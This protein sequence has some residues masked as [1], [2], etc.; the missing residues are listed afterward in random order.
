MSANLQDDMVPLPESSGDVYSLLKIL[1]GTAGNVDTFRADIKSSLRLFGLALK[2]EIV[3]GNLKWIT[4]LLEQ[5]IKDDPLE[6]FAAACE[7]VP[8]EKRIA[9][10]SIRLFPCPTAVSH[11]NAD[12]CGHCG[13][14]LRPLTCRC[15]YCDRTST[16]KLLPPCQ[17]L[18]FDGKINPATWSKQYIQ[19]LGILNYFAYVSAW[20]SCYLLKRTSATDGRQIL[21]DLAN[22]FCSKLE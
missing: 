1:T 6:C 13:R 2:Y 9:K 14:D 4:S 22:A 11:P 12:N 7:H 15:H 19:R 5:F 8:T 16:Y 20:S 18:V 3:G 17:H 10:L 21:V